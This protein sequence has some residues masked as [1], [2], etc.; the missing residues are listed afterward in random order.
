MWQCLRGVF[1]QADAGGIPP[2]MRGNK[3]VLPKDAQ[4]KQASPAPDHDIEAK[5]SSRN[6]RELARLLHHCR[7]GGESLQNTAAISGFVC[8]RSII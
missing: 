1:G 6:T 4:G 5:I 8:R 7:C 2:G 3:A